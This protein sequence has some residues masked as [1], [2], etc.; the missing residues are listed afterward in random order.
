MET[1]N[2]MGGT[3]T[4]TDDGAVWTYRAITRDVVLKAKNKGA[5]KSRVDGY[6]RSNYNAHREANRRQ[7][8]AG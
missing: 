1:E 2:Y 5:L 3:I 7:Q 6:L 8:R 4:K